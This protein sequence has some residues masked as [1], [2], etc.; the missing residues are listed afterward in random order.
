MFLHITNITDFIKMK[1]LLVG[2]YKNSLWFAFP[3]ESV[4]VSPCVQYVLEL[5][6]NQWKT[7][8]DHNFSHEM[9]VLISQK[10]L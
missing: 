2:F 4:Y 8:V 1:S 7:Y 10:K 6:K 9:L 5:K 3:W